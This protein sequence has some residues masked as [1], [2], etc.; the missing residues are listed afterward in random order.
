VYGAASAT[1]RRAAFETNTPLGDAEPVFQ[2]HCPQGN[3]P[4]L[5]YPSRH[6]T[7]KGHWIIGE[8]LLRKLA[9]IKGN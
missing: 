1:V 6:P 8:A 4:D 9:D 5:Y 3:C 2:E 7:S